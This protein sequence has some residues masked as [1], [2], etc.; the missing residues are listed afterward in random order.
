MSLVWW[1]AAL[2]GLLGLAWALGGLADLL[3]L[4]LLKGLRAV[5]GGSLLA[6]A[7]TAFLLGLDLLTYVRLADERPVATIA[8]REAGP[9]LYD[10]TL[11]LAPTEAVPDGATAAYRLHGDEWRIEARVLKWQPWANVLGFD[12]QVRLDRLS[13]RYRDT[14]SELTAPRSAFDLAPVPGN[15][16]DLWALA[17]RWGTML[18]VV[19][20]LYGSAA[21]MPMADGARFEVL[22]T[23]SGLIARPANEA[24]VKGMAGGWR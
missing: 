21:F 9:R 18:P 24:A 16:I 15:P 22:V 17:R 11:A 12:A 5:A 2:L 23:Q 4:R 3:R 6:L 14:L 19:D 1:L 7:A 8:L 10:A 13:G 20:A